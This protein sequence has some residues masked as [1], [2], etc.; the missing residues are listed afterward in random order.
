MPL[1][2]NGWMIWGITDWLGCNHFECNEAEYEKASI[3][4][5]HTHKEYKVRAGVC[6]G[7]WEVSLVV[8]HRGWW[9]HTSIL[10]SSHTQTSKWQGRT[11][12]PPQCSQIPAGKLQ[13]WPARTASTEPSQPKSQ[14]APHCF[15]YFNF[16][17]SPISQLILKAISERD[18][19]VFASCPVQQKWLKI[20]LKRGMIP[21]PSL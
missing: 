14:I 18:N 19:K 2:K 4:H 20:C 17:H 11:D 16:F 5:T 10:T 6:P 13:L 21:I 8:R 7:S 1:W 12:D 15:L 9:T 3:K